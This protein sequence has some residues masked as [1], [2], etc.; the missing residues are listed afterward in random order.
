MEITIIHGQQHRGSTYHIAGIL[1]N[2]L[3]DADTVVNEYFLPKDGPDFCVGC[4]GC[5]TKGETH[6]P[7]ANKVQPVVA[8]LCRAQ[9]LIFDSPTYCFEMTGQLKTLFDHL[10]YLW[11]S[12]RPRAE[13]FT[14]IG[15]VVSTAAGAGTGV[16]AKSMARQL[17]WWGVTKVYRLRHHVSAMS[18]QDVAAGLKQK[19]ER[20]TSAVARQVRARVGR[21]R[22]GLK[23]RLLFAVMR[24]MHTNNTWNRIDKEYWHEKNWVAKARPWRT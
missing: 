3:A 2:Q 22:P 21:V 8:A 10:G 13:M 20:Q 6:C 9:I 16:V 23:T 11:L 4:F 18:W 5:I 24:K 12:H 14:K 1:K 17:S 15:I 19:I 7:H